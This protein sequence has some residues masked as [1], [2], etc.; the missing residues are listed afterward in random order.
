MVIPLLVKC[1]RRCLWLFLMFESLCKIHFGLGKLGR[2]WPNINSPINFFITTR[3]RLIGCLS[4]LGSC[5]YYYHSFFFCS[6]LL[7]PGVEEGLGPLLL[8]LGWHRFLQRCW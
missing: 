5:S 2:L 3:G 7:S 4:A 1:G 6:L 8:L